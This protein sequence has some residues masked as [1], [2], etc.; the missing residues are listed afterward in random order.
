MPTFAYR[1]RGTGGEPVSG[2]LVADT[3][4]AAARA[5]TER[6]LLP[7]ELEEVRPQGRSLLTGRTRR[8]PA[9]QVG[10]FYEQLA[11]LLR[12][13]VPLLRALDV[14]VRQTSNRALRQVLREVQDAVAQGEP[15]ADALERYPYAFR[16]LHVSMIRAGETGGFLEDVLT[17]VAEF[18]ARQDELRNR[19]V[20]SMIYP[21]IL[22]T[23]VCGA[24]TLVMTFVVP[25][26]RMIIQQQELA[27]PTRV[28]FG[29]SDALRYHG[30]EVAGTALV[31]GLLVLMYLRSGSGR[32]V[33]AWLALR[34]PGIGR[35]YTLVAL[36]RFCRTL[37]T[38][39]G[40]GIPI[41][42]ALRVAKDATGNPILAQSIEQAAESV[43]AGESLTRPLVESRLF[44][45]A[46]IDMIAVAE[47]S[48]TLEKVL[49]E[50]A[51]TQEA[52]TARQIDLFVR[53]L[54]PLMLLLMGA[55]VT[56]IAFALLLPILKMST[57]GFR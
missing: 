35:I 1:A 12:A 11:D 24:T 21:V 46:M 29:I 22:L 49:I 55:V 41:L 15:L 50:I 27:W 54:E 43:R 6:S 57:S 17:R 26:I 14:L 47:E 30:L 28:V 40:N 13:G 8:I 37:G 52:R 39:L 36:C 34:A 2:T 38:L 31:A 20:A 51:D 32:H 18:V 33:R 19:F 23:L 44:P 16:P 53:L 10:L 45:P 42:T 5:L 3:P 7:V 56:F 48:N 25:R 9:S 4:A